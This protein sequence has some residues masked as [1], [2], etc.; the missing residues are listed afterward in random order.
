[1]SYPLDGEL[2]PTIV[3]LFH[4]I[5]FV[6]GLLHELLIDV[7]AEPASEPK[8]GYFYAGQRTTSKSE[9]LADE[10]CRLSFSGCF[11]LATK[12]K[13]VRW[14][15]IFISLL[16]KKGGNLTRKGN[17]LLRMGDWLGG[18]VFTARS[19][20]ALLRSCAARAQRLGS[21]RLCC[22]GRGISPLTAPATVDSPSAP[23]AARTAPAVLALRTRPP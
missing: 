11:S 10:K 16:S 15:L 9:D 3:V 14:K 12:P 7:N 6:R 23:P 1:M 18:L 8:K 17:G 22:R 2:S 21:S 20:S 13:E 4:K 5:N 19:A